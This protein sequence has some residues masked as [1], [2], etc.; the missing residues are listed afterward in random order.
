MSHFKHCVPVLAALAVLLALTHSSL[1]GEQQ[2]GCKDCG[3]D[4]PSEGNST[5]GEN[6]LLA[7]NYTC[8]LYRLYTIG[9]NDYM[10]YAEYYEGGCASDPWPFAVEA[11]DINPIPQSCPETCIPD[12]FAARAAV[13]G[14]MA[15]V[16]H[17]APKTFQ[18]FDPALHSD[19]TPTWETGITTVGKTTFKR[20]H[21]SKEGRTYKA[22]V[23]DVNLPNGKSV[24]V[25]FEINAFP[26]G[27]KSTIIDAGGARRGVGE[28]SY[29]IQN[30][31]GKGM[32]F[33]TD[34]DG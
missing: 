20:I 31:G 8:I 2:R 13:T 12:T 7:T 17:Y 28:H 32:I 15:T 3:G 9:P 10:Y 24:Y 14:E 16:E 19:F 27:E 21:F 6:S 1:L 34:V 23:F 25:A 33:L 29:S 26:P 22:K 4:S 30:I 5:S 11:G 18:G